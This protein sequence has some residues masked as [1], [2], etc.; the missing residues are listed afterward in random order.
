[1]SCSLIGDMRCCDAGGAGR[2]GSGGA[3]A[4]RRRGAGGAAR[5]RRHAAAAGAQ[6]QGCH[7]TH[8]GN[9][10]TTPFVLY[11]LT[12]TLYSNSDREINE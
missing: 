12:K 3:V 8:Q 7:R 11:H 6:P 4:G 5:R 9:G 1:M 10:N 2:R